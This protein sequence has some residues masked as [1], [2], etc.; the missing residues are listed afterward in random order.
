MKIFW[1]VLEELNSD[2]E[3]PD[4]GSEEIYF[5]DAQSLENFYQSSNFETFC[6][7]CGKL[8][9]IEHHKQISLN[10]F[11]KNMKTN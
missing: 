1:C 5:E 3:D 8:I 6:S 11:T 4:L 7:F 2:S 10:C 9:C